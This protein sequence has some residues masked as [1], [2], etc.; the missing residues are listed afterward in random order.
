MEHLKRNRSFYANGL[1]IV[2]NVVLATIAA[3]DF[4]IGMCWG[5][6]VTLMFHVL[7]CMADMTRATYNVADV[8]VGAAK[9]M[10]AL[11]SQQ[12][13]K[14]NS[15]YQAHCLVCASDMVTGTKKEMETLL[16][17]EHK[18]CGSNS[19][20]VY[21]GTKLNCW[22]QLKTHKMVIRRMGE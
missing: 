22:Q 1:F 15:M 13:G 16:N 14:E 21:R 8:I 18:E 6:F 17:N 19:I 3:E 11:Q 9:F 12:K 2:L 7:S 20:L 10:A 5:A 4:F